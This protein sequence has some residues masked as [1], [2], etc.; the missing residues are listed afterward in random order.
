MARPHTSAGRIHHIGWW[1]VGDREFTDFLNRKVN[2]RRMAYVGSGQRD[3]PEEHRLVYGALAF[4]AT[5][6]NMWR[7][8]PIMVAIASHTLPPACP[9]RHG[10]HRHANARFLRGPVHAR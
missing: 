3:I 2:L 5:S 1:Q 9:S 4:S 7:A 10:R 6:M 8:A